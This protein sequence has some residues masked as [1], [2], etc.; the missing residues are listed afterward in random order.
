MP[1]T[2]RCRTTHE[3]T[4][5]QHNPNVQ[6][7]NARTDRITYTIQ[8]SHHLPRTPP[9]LQ[10][11]IDTAHTWHVRLNHA[12]VSTAQKMANSQH[13]HGLLC[14]FPSSALSTHYSGCVVGGMVRVP[15]TGQTLLALHR[16]TIATDIMGPI[17][18]TDQGHQYIITLVD[19]HTRMAIAYLLQTRSEANAR[20][21]EACQVIQRP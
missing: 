10:T 13:K 3:E 11:A 1:K 17:P 18:K 9:K 14:H 6:V 8:H 4:S 21:L 5:M 12:A 15:H 20:I 7:R 19:L 2:P 16:H